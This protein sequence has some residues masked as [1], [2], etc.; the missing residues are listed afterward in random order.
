MHSEKAQGV[1]ELLLLIGGVT[2]LSAV[3]LVFLGGTASPAGLAAEAAEEKNFG[4]LQTLK[5]GLGFPACGDGAIDEGEFCDCWKWQDGGCT[6]STI[7][8]PFYSPFPDGSKDCQPCDPELDDF[9]GVKEIACTY[10]CKMDCTEC[11]LW[12]ARQN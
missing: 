3:A 5:K 6:Y 12:Y 1:I 9:I 10:D 11:W 7:E 8:D 2:M 4:S